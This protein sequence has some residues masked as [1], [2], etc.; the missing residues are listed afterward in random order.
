MQVSVTKQLMDSRRSVARQ[1]FSLH[2]ESSA[3][4]PFIEQFIAE[5]YQR[6]H[7]AR[8]THFLPLLMHLAKE[9]KPLAALGLRPGH[10]SA[11]FLEQ[12]LDSPIEQQIASMEKQPVDR[13][14]LIEIGNL[15]VLR[16]SAGLLLFMI[17]AMSLARAGFEWM[18]FTVTEQ[19]ERLIGQLGFNPRYLSAV[20][21]TLARGQWG[22]YY[23][24]NP[25]VMIGSLR[26]AS[27]LANSSSFFVAMLSAYHNDITA[28][29]C[30]LR[31]YCRLRGG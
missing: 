24:K 22:S 13:C 7:N 20:D 6:T 17:M 11:M 4:R 21:S 3:D 26:E 27:E 29:A 12:Y 23:E 16:K 1:Q 30:S 19:T 10:Y 2:S 5:R 8:I 15:A 14:S 18:V 31:D 9:N 28:I 25:R